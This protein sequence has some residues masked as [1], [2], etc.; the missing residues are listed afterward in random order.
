MGC[1]CKGFPWKTQKSSLKSVKPHP[2]CS[3]ASATRVRAAISIASRLL[4]STSLS[5]F[6]VCA[7]IRASSFAPFSTSSPICRSW[8][9]IDCRKNSIHSPAVIVSILYK[10]IARSSSLISFHFVQA[11]FVRLRDAGKR[12]DVDRVAIAHLRQFADLPVIGIRSI[13]SK[14]HRVRPAPQPP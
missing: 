7:A 10:R 4:I 13:A 11:M 6:A 3:C 9:S 8:D 5:I 1:P 14:I 2:R 12:G